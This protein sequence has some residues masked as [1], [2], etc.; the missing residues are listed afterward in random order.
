M[1]GVI[2]DFRTF[3]LRGNVVD[4]AVGVVIGVAFGA[5]VTALVKDLIT[6][7]IALVFGKHDF[8]AL[9]FAI[10]GSTFRYGDFIN[11]L[12]AFL[13]VATAVFFFVV[14]PVNVLMARRRT[15]PDADSETRS[16]TECL[17]DIPLQARRCAFCTSEQVPG[18]AG[19]ATA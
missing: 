18:F 17:S 12:I 13:S 14:Q 4:L 3:I 2:R 9:T 7:I 1:A 10:N 11:A 6:P 16:C 5:V 8:S 19:P 15:Q